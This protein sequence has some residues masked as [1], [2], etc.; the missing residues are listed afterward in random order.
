[1]TS[2][3]VPLLAAVVL[4]GACSSNASN[5]PQPGTMTP[6]R[7]ADGRGP[8]A[9]GP[10]GRDSGGMREDMAMRGITLSGDQQA[11]IDQI[12]ASYRSQMEQARASGSVDRPAMRAMMEK[13]QGDIRG[14]LTTE[15]QE[16][17]DKNIADMRAR[18]RQ[19]GGRPP[20]V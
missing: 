5:A 16:Q 14:I 2:R 8:D 7:S 11:R 3:I 9:R 15:Q 10:G 4:L 17:F 20:T 12:R 18:M 1:M 13:Q 19:G 6:S